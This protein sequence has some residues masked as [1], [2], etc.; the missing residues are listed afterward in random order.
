MISQYKES[1]DATASQSRSTLY[2]VLVHAH[3]ISTT[4]M[5]VLF[6]VNSVNLHLTAFKYKLHV[7]TFV[8]TCKIN[9]KTFIYLTN[10]TVKFIIQF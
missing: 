7:S 6:V 3:T 1:D 10:R 4:G 8:H 9:R 2:G 5:Q